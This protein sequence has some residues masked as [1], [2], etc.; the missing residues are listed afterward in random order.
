[1][2]TYYAN[3]SD[4]GEQSST[5]STNFEDS[6]AEK[7]AKAMAYSLL[8]IVSVTGNVL[9][10]WAINRDIRLR[11]NTNILVANM[12]FSDIF[13]AVFGFPRRVYEVG[14]QRRWLADDDFGLALCKLIPFLKD[15]SLFVSV[16]SCISIAIDRYFAVAHPF[17]GGFSRSRLKYI[18]PGIWVVAILAHSPYF[19]SYRLKVDDKGTLC[20]PDWSQ[21]GVPH[22][23][24]YRIY[25]FALYTLMRVIPIPFITSLYLMIVYKVRK[26]R[27][28]GQTSLARMKREQQNKK[29]LKM[30]IAIVSIFFLS[31]ATFDIYLILVLLGKIDKSSV[32]AQRLGFTAIFLAESSCAY[33]FFIY[34]FFNNIYRQNFTKRSTKKRNNGDIKDLQL[35]NASDK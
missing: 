16:Y 30:S 14:N 18:I 24:V 32:V 4:P 23:F 28:P 22:I 35:L 7:V 11:T 27:V 6:L 19:Y 20:L 9:I 10:I 34:L 31:W 2:F 17:R 21:A 12:A 29:I 15:I 26:N 5:N 13:T 33:N 3:L 1:M 8:F 25:I